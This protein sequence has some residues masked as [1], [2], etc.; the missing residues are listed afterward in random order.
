[1]TCYL[2]QDH[3]T[4]WL[5]FTGLLTSAITIKHLWIIGKVHVKKAKSLS[6]FLYSMTRLE[7]TPNSNNFLL[8][9]RWDF[10]LCYTLINVIPRTLVFL[11]KGYSKH[12]HQFYGTSSLTGKQV[13]FP[14]CCRTRKRANRPSLSP[15]KKIKKN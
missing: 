3:S 5:F 10:A 2:V 11:W 14:L 15:Q 1:L 7:S 8:L 4:T 13:S 9:A 12:K 6:N